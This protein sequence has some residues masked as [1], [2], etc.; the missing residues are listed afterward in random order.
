M[1]CNILDKIPD[2][3]VLTAVVIILLFRHLDGR[4]PKE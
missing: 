4:K 1:S 2:G 3:M